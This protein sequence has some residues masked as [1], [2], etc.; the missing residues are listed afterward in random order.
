MMAAP[1]RMPRRVSRA[2]LAMASTCPRPIASENPAFLK[3]RAPERAIRAAC[4]KRRIRCVMSI[5]APLARCGAAQHVAS[6]HSAPGCE[7][8]APPLVRSSSAPEDRN[9][10]LH[11]GARRRV[12]GGELE[13][14]LVGF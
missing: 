11:L 12:G 6:L 3:M 4:F 7:N 14:T 8:P 13:V 9:V 5:I 10:L 1:P 2:V